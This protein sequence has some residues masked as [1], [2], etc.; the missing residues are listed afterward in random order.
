MKTRAAEA[1]EDAVG[2]AGPFRVEGAAVAALAVWGD[3]GRAGGVVS[4]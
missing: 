1:N 2:D 3:G 4:E